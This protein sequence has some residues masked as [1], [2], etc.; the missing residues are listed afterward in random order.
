MKKRSRSM[1]SAICLLVALAMA[2]SALAQNTAQQSPGGLAVTGSI[3]LSILNIPFKAVT[4]APTWLVA[5][6]AYVATAGVP[7]GYDGDTNGKD[8]A[9]I[10]VGACEG[11]WVITPS[12]VQEDYGSR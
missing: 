2:P 12:T 5:N 1:K 9:E 4:C 10:A 11:P 3:F 8:I 6:T 7:G